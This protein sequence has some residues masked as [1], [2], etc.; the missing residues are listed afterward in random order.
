MHG[1]RFRH[2]RGS[3]FLGKNRMEVRSFEEKR[4]CLIN[5]HFGNIHS[6]NALYSQNQ[7]CWTTTFRT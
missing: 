5:N 7:Q 4:N 1:E 6:G 3:I 2:L